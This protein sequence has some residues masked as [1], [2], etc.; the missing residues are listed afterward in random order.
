[1]I[2]N[3]DLNAKRNAT[4]QESIKN[5]EKAKEILDQRL[6]KKEISHDE[7]LKKAYELDTQIQKYKQIIGQEF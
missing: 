6:Q 3:T 1:M 7:Y 4:Y 5:L 2:F